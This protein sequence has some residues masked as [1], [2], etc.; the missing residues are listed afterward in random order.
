MDV[1][2]HLLAIHPRMVVQK[3]DVTVL[4]SN[5]YGQRRLHRT[6][7]EKLSLTRLKGVD[8]L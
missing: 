7:S 8:T 3:L 6:L 2:C 5:V 1:T 4:C